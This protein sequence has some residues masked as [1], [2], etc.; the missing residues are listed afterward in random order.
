MV[1][2]ELVTFLKDGF[3][4]WSSAGMGNALLP[5]FW[6]IRES[7][8]LGGESRERGCVLTTINSL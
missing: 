8:L 3:R 5:V 2:W 4:F 6:G 7:P 1:T